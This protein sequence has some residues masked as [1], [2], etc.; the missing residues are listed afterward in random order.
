[1]GFL[2]LVLVISKIIQRQYF[3]QIYNIVGHFKIVLRHFLIRGKKGEKKT[4][5]S[6]D[7]K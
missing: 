6:A 1:M 7:K 2:S 4:Y 3:W 5:L